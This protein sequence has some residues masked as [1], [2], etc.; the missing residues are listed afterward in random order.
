MLDASDSARYRALADYW[1]HIADRTTNDLMEAA[2]L[3]LAE[4]YDRLALLFEKE[5]PTGSN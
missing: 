3:R 5:S 4:C 1:R 2:Y